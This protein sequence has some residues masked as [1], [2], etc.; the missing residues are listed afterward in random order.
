M[1]WTKQSAD[2]TKQSAGPV[3]CT[4]S[5][6]AVAPTHRVHLSGEFFRKCPEMPAARPFCRLSTAP[7]FMM[8]ANS[9]TSRSTQLLTVLTEL[10]SPNI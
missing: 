3:S 9:T 1:D 4:R 8:M 10:W 5:A 6:G 7:S 2:W